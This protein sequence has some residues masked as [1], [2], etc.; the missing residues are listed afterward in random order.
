MKLRNTEQR[1]GLVSVIIHWFTA[2][3]VVGMFA[4]GLWMVELTYYDH[5]Y[6]QAPFIHKSIG[7][8]LFLLTLARLLWRWS[9]PR[10]VELT[11]HS[12]FEKRA[13]RIAH[14]LI[15]LLLFSIMI[16][17]YLI[18]TADGR[19]VDVFNWFSIPATVHG[20]E[21][22]EDIAGLIHLVLAVSLIT[23]VTMHAA[24]ALKHHFVDRDRTLSR[25]LGK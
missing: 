23:L 6:R 21:Q 5:W 14:G 17:G 7:V 3:A 15:Y 12:A 24:A 2:I 13:A 8:L 4:L 9:N 20:H 11:G 25:I 18:S 22:Q 10:P 19:A 16:S 1:W